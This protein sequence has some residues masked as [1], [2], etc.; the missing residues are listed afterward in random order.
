MTEKLVTYRR[1]RMGD[2]GP[3]WTELDGPP[4]TTE[5]L[6]GDMTIENDD[7]IVIVYFEDEAAHSFV[8]PRLRDAVSLAQEWMIPHKPARGS[9]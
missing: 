7:Q 8:A 3:E 1:V 9:G 4:E 2:A 6:F 5:G